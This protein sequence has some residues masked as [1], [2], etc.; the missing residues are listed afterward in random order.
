MESVGVWNPV[1]HP[2]WANVE[3]RLD[4]EIEALANGKA[5]NRENQVHLS[6]SRA[7]LISYD[8]YHVQ[9]SEF[10]YHAAYALLGEEGKALLARDG[11]PCIVR[12]ELPGPVALDAANAFLSVD[13]LRKTGIVPNL[14]NEFLE[15]WSY[16]LGHPD[17]K[18]KT[19]NLD[20]CLLFRSKIPAE[21]I[22]DVQQS[23]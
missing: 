22:V 19:L 6:V 7:G 9:G 13:H 2:N 16:R 11:K 18:S 3:S 5:G 1:S 4:V 8:S 10:D 23:E 20:L 14:V 17:Y 21:C 15:V 12:V